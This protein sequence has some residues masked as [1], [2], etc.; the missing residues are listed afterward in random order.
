MAMIMRHSV[1]TAPA[2]VPPSTGIGLLAPPPTAGVLAGV[3]R[4]N[5]GGSNRFEAA[6]QTVSNVNIN[7]GSDPIYILA[8]N[9]TFSNCLIATT[10]F[11][12]IDADYG[13]TGLVVDHCTFTTTSSGVNAPILTGDNWTVTNCLISG[14]FD[15]GI[16]VQGG[17]GL[18]TGNYI[19]SL[20]VRGNWANST[21]Y[22]AGQNLRD[23][24]GSSFWKCQTS[25]TSPATGTFA[26][27]R[28]ANPS[29]WVSIDP[30][31]DGIQ[32]N[33]PCNG[34]TIRGNWVESFDTSDIIISSGGGVSQNVTVE[35]NTLIGAWGAQ[36]AYA[37]YVEGPGMRVINNRLQR[38]AFGYVTSQ[39]PDYFASGNVDY[40]TGAPISGLV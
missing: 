35:G 17:T 11:F 27:D 1:L 5:W 40:F 6:G 2:P 38:G 12:A 31:V 18:C 20:G 14:G 16:Q 3:P 13:F 37:I 29:R 21:A 30:H 7:F 10:S 8:N 33:G 36:T 19:H 26:A 15:N 24:A 39:Q 22:T 25:H 23:A 32:I 4:T 28:T 9:V 34:V